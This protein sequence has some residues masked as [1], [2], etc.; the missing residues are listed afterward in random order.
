VKP[1]G[2]FLKLAAVASS[3]L[4]VGGFVSY[5]AGA[6]DRLLG[7]SARPADPEL[8]PSSK[9]KQILVVPTTTQQKDPALL[10]GSKSIAI[11]PLVPA[12]GPKEQA[13]PPSTSTTTPAER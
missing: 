13:A 5:R 6:F 2:A 3:L 10:P 4:L 11:S 8:L 7:T 9:V 12:P 1:P